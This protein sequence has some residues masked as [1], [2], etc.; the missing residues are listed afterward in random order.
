MQSKITP[1]PGILSA[2][3]TLSV[4][5]IVHDEENTL[6]R[7]LKSVEGLADE[8]VVVDTG[9]NDKTISLA[10]KFKARVF[11]FTWCDD[12]S[13]ARNLYLKQAAGDWILQIDADEELLPE[14]I[15]VIQERLLD[16]WCLLYTITADNGPGY[17]DRF[18]HPGRL[19]RN[20]PQLHYSRPYHETLRQ[21]ERLL[22]QA[23]P[24]W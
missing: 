14:S 23:E 16:P 8:I 21:S 1:E 18:F 20:H 3:P 17:P 15:P 4:C 12:F 22:R 19:F 9:P 10:R 7:C 6:P 11:H 24:R 5:M 13:A 2:K